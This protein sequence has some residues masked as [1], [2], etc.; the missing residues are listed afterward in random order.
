M[1]HLI[2]VVTARLVLRP[3][4]LDDLD[5]IQAAKEDALRGGQTRWDTHA[6]KFSDRGFV[7]GESTWVSDAPAKEPGA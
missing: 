6:N 7:R 1:R 2:P 3:P 4:I 5:A